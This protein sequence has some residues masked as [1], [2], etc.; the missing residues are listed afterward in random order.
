MILRLTGIGLFAAFVLIAG[1]SWRNSI[2]PAGIIIHHSATG[3]HSTIRS[4]ES[5]HESRGFGTFYWGKVYYVGYHYVIYPD[6]MVI[7][8]R[9]EHLRGAHTRGYNSYIGI[10]LIGD[11]S[12]KENLHGEKGLRKPTLNQMRSLYYLCERL[13]RRYGFVLSQIRRHS[14]VN[15]QTDC[16]GDRFP[17]Q[18]LIAKLSDTSDNSAL[19]KAAPVAQ[20]HQSE[21][22]GY[23]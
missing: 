8:T 2:H 12:S 20:R 19:A 16:P 7:A 11:F 9:P 23:K 13:R 15:K 21:N 22:G 5:A 4:I 10:C 18:D 3:Y 17:Y 1:V 6:G 14:D